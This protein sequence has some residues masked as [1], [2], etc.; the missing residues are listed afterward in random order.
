MVVVP[1]VVLLGQL[2][3]AGPATRMSRD[4][5]IANS[6]VL[7]GD[8]ER[9]RG[10]FGYYPETLLAVNRDYK[11]GVIGIEGYDYSRIGNGFN[12]VF[13]QPRL[14]VD[15]PGVREFV[16]YNPLDEHVML[17]HAEWYTSR[18]AAEVAAHQGGFPIRPTEHPHWKSYLFD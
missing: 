13:E 14:L 18:P 15:E 5:A 2:I 3:L 8:L 12:L 9:F 7:L 6:S 1:T 10:S 4:R 11:P 16:V 17:S